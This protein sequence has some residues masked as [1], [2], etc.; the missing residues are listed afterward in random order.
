VI[1]FK[2]CHITHHVMI[3]HC[4]GIVMCCQT[5]DASSDV[6][7]R[8]R[9]RGR[10]THGC[11]CGRGWLVLPELS[12][13]LPRFLSVKN[14]SHYTYVEY[15]VDDKSV[16]LCVNFEVSI[17]T[18]SKVREGISQNL[19]RLSHDH[20]PFVVIIL[21]HPVSLVMSTI[22]IILYYARWQHSITYT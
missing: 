2:F 19:K 5:C 7:W 14:Y 18:S 13:C 9:H 3:R 21:H 16:N 10:Q 22:I 6:R 15:N 1:T 20:A 12:W 11:G 17:F 4:N 8:I